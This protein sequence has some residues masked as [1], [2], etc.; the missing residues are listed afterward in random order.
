M[1]LKAPVTIDAPASAANNTIFFQESNFLNTTSRNWI[2]AQI[3][4]QYKKATLIYRSSRDGYTNADFHKFV[5][6][7]GPFIAIGVMAKRMIV[8]GYTSLSAD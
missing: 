5:D 4:S 6:G 7:K 1:Q 3:P 8:A 2:A